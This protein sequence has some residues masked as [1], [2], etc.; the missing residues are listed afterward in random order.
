M[1]TLQVRADVGHEDPV[2]LD[3]R[4]RLALG[5]EQVL[6]FFGGRFCVDVRQRQ[7]DAQHLVAAALG[8]LADRHLR[9]QIRRY[10]V[11]VCHDEKLVSPHKDVA[12]L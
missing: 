10:V 7:H 1:D 6:D 4:N 5:T 2:G 9:N 8:Q 12:L 3:E 11:D